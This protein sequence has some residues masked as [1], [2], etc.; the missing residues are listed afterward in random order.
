MLLDAIPK[1]HDTGCAF[2]PRCPHAN[3]RCRTE[4]PVLQALHGIKV[5][6]HA[7]QEGRI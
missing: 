6:C 4:R 7:L 5:A 2:Y 1:T 3:V